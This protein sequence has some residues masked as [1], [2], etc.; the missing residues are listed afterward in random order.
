[1]KN[2][3]NYENFLYEY[4]NMEFVSKIL[5]N[6]KLKHSKRVAELTKLIKDD[7]DIYAASVYHDF[8]ERGGDVKDM[9]QTLSKHALELAH[10]LTNDEDEDTLL[11]LQKSLY[12]KP[13][14]IINDVLTI[15]ICDRF[16]NLKR[17]MIKNELSKKYI[18]KSSELIQ[19]IWDNFDGDK[20]KLEDFIKKKIFVYIP[21][22]SKKI[23]LK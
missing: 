2:I 22:I 19:W 12:N 21:K 17:K 15:K 1:M 13:K 7:E 3:L 5:S 10:L 23:E 8:L 16:D 18:R 14:N 11:K 6:K 4:V 20:S 9:E